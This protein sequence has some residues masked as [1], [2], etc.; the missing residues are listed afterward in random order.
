MPLEK[1][2]GA[3]I[4]K[5]EKEIEY[6]LLHYP[7]SVKSVKD[8][9]DFPKGHIEKDEEELDTLKREVEEETGLKDIK[10]IEGFKELIRYF[11]K[12]QGKTI[13]KTVVFYLAESQSKGIKISTEHIGNQ[14]LP[15]EKALAKLNYENAKEILKKAN[16]FLLFPKKI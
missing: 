11:F 10:I 16:N 9:W 4:F 3:V 5:K 14:W 7:S 15:F 12:F 1:S 8:Y 6:L 2:V 13:L